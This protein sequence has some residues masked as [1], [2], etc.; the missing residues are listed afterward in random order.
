MK[1][2]VILLLCMM[3]SVVA[4]GQKKKSRIEK[5]G[6]PLH[7][8]TVIAPG[9]STN[10]PIFTGVIESHA[11]E[12][13]A[14]LN[15]LNQYL[16]KN[17]QYPEACK[18]RCLEGTEIVQFVVSSKGEVSNFKVINSISPQI[19]DE[20]I[21]VLKTTNK[22][23]KPGTNVNGL[24]VASTKEVSIAFFVQMGENDELDFLTEAIKFYNK[25]NVQLY[26]KENSKAAL[27]NY[28]KAICYLPNDKC[29]LM[30][31]GMC[32]YELGDKDGAYR[33]W[34]RIR[35]LGG[36]EGDALL[37]N[38]GGFKGYAEMLSIVNGKG[39]M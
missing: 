24:P 5:E 37:E 17:V 29:L 34:T 38:L 3:F 36:F 16:Q 7:E 31:R 28:N 23:W 9:P 26:E 12:K 35:S 6:T 15:S 2:A 8:V 32:R 18:A 11:F 21:R 30:V 27:K 33:D 10:P 25:G 19:D 4:L 20:L 1:K 22:M 39:Q 14:T 13:E